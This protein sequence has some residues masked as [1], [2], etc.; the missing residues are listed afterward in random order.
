MFFQGYNLEKRK[1]AQNLY[2]EAFHTEKCKKLYQVIITRIMSAT[3]TLKSASEQRVRTDY[4]IWN[5]AGR[6]QGHFYATCP[7]GSHDLQN[8][9]YGRPAN[10]NTL[11]TRSAE[12]NARADLN[13]TAAGH[14]QRENNERPY[15]PIAAAGMRGAGDLMAVGRDLMPQ[16]LYGEGNRGNFVRHGMYAN[17]LPQPAD[18]L[19]PVIT[20]RRWQNSQL[21]SNDATSVY[22]VR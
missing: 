20:E 14:I 17:H 1:T 22:F 5:A 8:D 9:I 15:V 11:D 16:D 10:R 13:D 19:P 21:P 3:Q 4:A 7:T 12:C 6:M 2:R 18:Q